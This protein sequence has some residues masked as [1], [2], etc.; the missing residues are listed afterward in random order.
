MKESFQI[1][2]KRSTIG[3]VRNHNGVAAEDGLF[4]SMIRQMGFI[5]FVRTNVPQNNMSF[6]T[7]NNIYGR[8]NN[9]WRKN[10]TPGGSS[11]G[12]GGLICGGGSLF[13]VGSDI[14]G[15]CRIPAAFCGLNT[16]MSQRFSKLGEVSYGQL[17][18]GL[19]NVRV[20]YCPITRSVDD[21][22]TFTH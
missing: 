10:R 7:S 15:S 20:A 16:I 3:F 9:P 11:G 18:D 12:E 1:K 22:V 5:P 2:G 19:L 4:V 14:G 8:A 17:N 13:G 6:E 21:L